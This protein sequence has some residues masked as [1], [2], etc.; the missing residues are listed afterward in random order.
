MMVVRLS[1]VK[2]VISHMAY[3]IRSATPR[4]RCAAA[5]PFRDMLAAHVIYASSMRVTCTIFTC[6]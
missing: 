4:I 6:M 1:L 5:E 2:H 3:G